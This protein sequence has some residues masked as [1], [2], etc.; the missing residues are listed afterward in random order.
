MRNA[1]SP[2]GVPAKTNNM[3]KKKIYDAAALYIE[4]KHSP[5]E[6]E[7]QYAMNIAAMKAFVAGVEY[8]LSNLW[9]SVDDEL[10]KLDEDVVVYY[11]SDDGEE[12]YMFSHRTDDEEVLTDK[13]GFCIYNNEKITHWQKLTKS[14]SE[15]LVHTN[16]VEGVAEHDIEKVKQILSSEIL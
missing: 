14:Q 10:P 9:T 12:N 1:T 16:A 2:I 15:H 13:N 4:T 3:E 5:A 6:N 7:F 11:V 8:A